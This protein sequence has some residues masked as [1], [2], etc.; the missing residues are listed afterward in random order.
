MVYFNVFGQHFLVLGSVQRTTDLFGKRSS[1]YSDR[2]QAPMLELYV[3]YSF[4]PRMCSKYLLQDGVWF[5]LC[6]YAIRRAVATT[7]GIISPAFS[8]KCG[9]QI[10]TYPKTRSPS[11]FASTTRHTRQLSL[12]HSTVSIVLSL[13]CDFV[14]VLIK[15]NKHICFHYYEHHIWYRHSGI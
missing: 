10:P 9:A 3:S 8:R 11:L 4:Q 13:I 6:P 14:R 1:N 5:Q 7:Q 12:P 2:V 15:G